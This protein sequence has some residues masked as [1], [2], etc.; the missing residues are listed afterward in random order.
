M[1]IIFFELNEVPYR[2]I[3][4]FCRLYPNSNLATVFN[5]GR[6]FETFAEDQGHLSPWVTWP[7]VHRGVSNEKHFTSDFGQ[8]I[9]DQEKEFPPLWNILAQEGVKVGVFGS[10]HTYPLP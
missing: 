8:D 7:T 5:K 2:I 9:N 4:L 6:K 10:L 3:H 1:K